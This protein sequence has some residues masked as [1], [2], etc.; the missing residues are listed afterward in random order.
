[1]TPEQ[2]E[3]RVEREMDRLD[4]KLMSGKIS[5][6]E[7]DYAVYKLDLWADQQYAHTDKYAYA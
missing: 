3:L 7:Y 5:Q 4:H 1:M 2:I 6:D